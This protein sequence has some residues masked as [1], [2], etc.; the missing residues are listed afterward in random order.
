MLKTSKP[1]KEVE[2]RACASLRQLLEQVPAIEFLEIEHEADGL[3]RH[4]D[5]VAHISVFGRPR[6]LVCEVKS[7]GQPRHV[8]TGLL[9][10]RDYMAHR[11]QGCLPLFIAPY[12]SIDAQTLC[13]QEGVGF[14]DFE[15]NARL[16]FDG[17]FIERQVESKPIVE[18]RELKSLFKPKSAQ[19]LR[20]MI[21]NPPQSGGV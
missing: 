9:Q 2:S 13:R 6:V 17:V 11:A 14:L 1:V 20:V 12:L 8:R 19:V 3:D 7:T 15:G 18:R 10:L 21:R 4:P 16:I 5:I